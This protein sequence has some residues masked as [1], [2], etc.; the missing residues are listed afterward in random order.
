VAD[1]YATSFL[2]DKI[3]PKIQDAADN[4]NPLTAKLEKSSVGVIQDARGNYVLSKAEIIAEQGAG[5]RA[6]G[7]LLPAAQDGGMMDAKWLLKYAYAQADIYGQHDL[8]SKAGPDQAVAS[9]LTQKSKS[10]SNTFIR[11]RENG[12]WGSGDNKLATVIEAV[13]SGLVCK[14]DSVRDL[15]LNM[16][17]DIHSSTVEENCT[18]TAID[19]DAKTF[20]VT[21]GVATDLTVDINSIV[22][23]ADSK[24]LAPYGIRKAIFPD[25]WDA[26]GV[27]WGTYANVNRA[28]TPVFR[29]VFK[30]NNGTLRDITL[31]LIDEL[32]F[33]LCDN[34]AGQNVWLFM[35]APILRGI[36]KLRQAQK[37]DTDYLD[38]ILGW[39]AP[40][41]ECPNGTWPMVIAPKCPENCIV[42]I[43]FD[44]TSLRRPF[45]VQ[46]TFGDNGQ[47]LR[48]VEG[49]D[50]FRMTL[51]EYLELVVTWPK[52]CGVL[53]DVRFPAA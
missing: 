38:L 44:V 26:G 19:P 18:I 21:Q 4:A 17:V 3:L 31:D 41:Y 23:R 36:K 2:R 40:R 8:L 29:S 22:T 45:P 20:T 27:T 5:W 10:L 25:S 52:R 43:D 46:F 6:I 32:V 37:L 13:S 35:T 11:M 9:I 42:A 7:E 30:H 48:N 12:L 51:K 49:Y 50:K 24:D 28:T 34:H 16:L 15:E 33:E 14:V 53:A 1:T 39:K 47:I